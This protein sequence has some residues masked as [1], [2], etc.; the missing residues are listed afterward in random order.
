MTPPDNATA[1]FTIRRVETLTDHE[2]AG[3]ADVLVDC[4]AGGASVGFVLPFD[5]R[6]AAEFW[7]AQAASLVDG[8]RLMF[9]A[10]DAAGV[11]GTVQ[12]VLAEM[13]NQPHRA[14]VAKMLVHRRGRRRGIGAA[15]LSTAETAA[16]AAGRSLLVLDT[17][18]GT[19]ADRLYTRLGWTRVG[20]IPDYAQ[21]PA[22][23]L[24]PTTFFFKRLKV[25]HGGD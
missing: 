11:V 3:L 6:D 19:D 8:R 25:A 18:T 9:V 22:G 16:I 2:V 4:V 5:V 13:P 12:V 23:E 7:R 20:E 14:D 17:I 21:L 15:L 24:A 10:E 1:D